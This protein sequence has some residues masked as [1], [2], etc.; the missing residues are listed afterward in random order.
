M[1]VERHPVNRPATEQ[2]VRGLKEGT[3]EVRETAEEP[4][5]TKQARVV[6]G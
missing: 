6:E 5:V 1:N 3:I 4:V 2:D